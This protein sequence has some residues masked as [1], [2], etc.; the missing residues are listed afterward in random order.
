[1][2]TETVKYF[3]NSNKYLEWSIHENSAWYKLGEDEY[4]FSE[5][6]WNLGIMTHTC[7]YRPTVIDKIESMKYWDSTQELSDLVL[8]YMVEKD[9][10]W[11]HWTIH[12]HLYTLKYTHWNVFNT[13]AMSIKQTK[14]HFSL[15]SRKTCASLHHL[16]SRCL[17]TVVG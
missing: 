3:E 7:T 14:I 17:L 8:N 5:S 12:S 2:H 6:I 11:Q 4:W 16:C 15:Y 10:R 9:E 13:T 1:M